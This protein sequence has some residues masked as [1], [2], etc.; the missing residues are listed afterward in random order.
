MKK[1]KNSTTQVLQML[2]NR[3]RASF[4]HSAHDWRFSNRQFFFVF[5]YPLYAVFSHAHKNVP[6]WPLKCRLWQV[7]SC[8][9]ECPWPLHYFKYLLE[10]QGFL[11]SSCGCMSELFSF[12]LYIYKLTR[13]SK[14]VKNKR[15]AFMTVVGICLFYE[16]YEVRNNLAD[17]HSIQMVKM[18]NYSGVMKLYWNIIIY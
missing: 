7:R 6:L 17:V 2:L 12:L 11:A 1:T 9:R 16:N 14:H 4:R 8:K 15:A 18:K 13:F 3:P 10:M 5:F